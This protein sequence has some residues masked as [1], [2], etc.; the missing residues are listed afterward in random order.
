[1]N[2]EELERNI[3]RGFRITVQKGRWDE[4]STCETK[5]CKRKQK[6]LVFS[7]DGEP[8]LSRLETMVCAEHL[9]NGVEKARK[10][11]EKSIKEQIQRSIE[12]IKKEAEEIKK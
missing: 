1:M 6:Y 12:R 8:K 10:S 9:S 7:W 4:K 11:N 2:K 3:R 5:G